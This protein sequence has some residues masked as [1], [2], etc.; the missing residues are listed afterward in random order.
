MEVMNQILEFLQRVEIRY[1]L[2]MVGGFI[3]KSKPRWLP[4]IKS[5]NNKQ[6]PVATGALNVVIVALAA[7]FPM[8]AM[9][10]A[11]TTGI[12]TAGFFSGITFFTVFE[13]VSPWL[14]G[15]GTHS[16][17]KNFRQRGSGHRRA[18]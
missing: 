4:A 3:L 18:R 8:A 9:P 12:V 13:L 2:T 11:S 14:M 6:I 15:T 5:F 16:T 1:V 7:L 10:D 17:V